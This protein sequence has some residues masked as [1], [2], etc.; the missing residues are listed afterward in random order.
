MFKLPLQN[1]Q[2]PIPTS[3]RFQIVLEDTTTDNRENGIHNCRYIHRNVKSV[4]SPL[5]VMR[6]AP[7][8][9]GCTHVWGHETSL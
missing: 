9:E 8:G 1:F 4:F 2:Q 5:S 7:C 6:A 3:I